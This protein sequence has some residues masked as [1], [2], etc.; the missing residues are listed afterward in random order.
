MSARSMWQ[1][2]LTVQKHKIAIKLYAALEDRQVHFHLLH[3]RDES[4]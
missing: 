3:K 1:G 2:M 4:H